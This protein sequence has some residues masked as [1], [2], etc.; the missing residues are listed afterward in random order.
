VGTK[1]N[2]NG[3]LQGNGLFLSGY[4]YSDKITEGGQTWMRVIMVGTFSDKLQKHLIFKVPLARFKAG[5]LNVDDK[6]ITA[7]L[8]NVRIEFTPPV[9]ELIAEGV[10][11]TLTLTS[12]NSA[13]GATIGGQA[14]LVLQKR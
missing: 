13:L 8:Y 1:S 3:K 11:G 7:R 10:R 4:S 5:T 6:E 9:K 2:A 14:Y 12:A